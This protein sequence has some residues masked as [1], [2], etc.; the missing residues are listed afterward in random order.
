LAF[1][2]LSRLP[3]PAGAQVLLDGEPAEDAAPLGHL[4]E[5]QPHGLRRVALAE[6]GVAE[7]HRAPLD[8]AAVQRSVPEMVRSSV[9]L[10]APLLPRTATTLPSGICMDTPR[11]AC[12]APP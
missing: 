4:H 10:P 7:A 3:M 9:L 12:T 11:S 2:A 8:L 6:V 1:A 5:A